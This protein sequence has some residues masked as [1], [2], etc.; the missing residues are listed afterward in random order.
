MSADEKMADANERLKKMLY[1]TRS[2]GECRVCCT[3]HRVPELD[4][5]EGVTCSS[6]QAAPLPGCGRYETR[7]LSCAQYACL[8]RSGSDVL[9]SKDERP[10]L[11]GIIVDAKTDDILS[12]KEAFPGGFVQA[13]D[14]LVRLARKRI[15]M[16]L[17][18]DSQSGVAFGPAEQ[19]P[20]YVQ[21]MS[22]VNAAMKKMEE[23][24][25]KALEDTLP[26]GH[27]YCPTCNLTFAHAHE[28]HP[29][30]LQEVKS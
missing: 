4:K 20:A 29:P 17:E 5:P 2:C 24:Q 10:D 18:A 23:A 8:W 19:L 25:A 28:D 26:P 14:I 16:L 3:T 9:P 1:D 15:V 7:P 11:S 22:V 27:K 13:K 6:R 12:I 30:A 21:F